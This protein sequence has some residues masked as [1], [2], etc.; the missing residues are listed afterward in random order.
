MPRLRLTGMRGIS[1]CGRR[2]LALGRRGPEASRSRRTHLAFSE[3]AVLHSAVAL[4]STRQAHHAPTVL[5]GT[6]SQRKM[7]DA[8]PVRPPHPADGHGVALVALGHQDGMG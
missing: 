8:G 5:D 2:L 3:T 1:R 6:R 7:F 4:F